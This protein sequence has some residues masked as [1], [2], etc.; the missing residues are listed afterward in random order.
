MPDPLTLAVDARCLDCGAAVLR[1]EVA[2][3]D[4]VHMPDHDCHR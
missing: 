3:G 4:A 1:T 2:P